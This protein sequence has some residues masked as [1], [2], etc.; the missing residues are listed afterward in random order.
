MVSPNLE[1][2]KAIEH[3]G[4]VLLS[5][6][7]GS[8]KTF[9]LENHV[10]YLTEQWIEDFQKKPQVVELRSYLR[11]KFKSVVLMTFT[12]KAAGELELRI[13]KSFE[14]KASESEI[15]Q[16]AL[17]ELPSLTVGTIHSFCLK[18]IS[19]GFFPNL[20]SAQRM[21][22]DS[23]FHA[24]IENYLE[25]WLDENKSF[26][27]TELFHK[28][29]KSL[30]Q[31]IQAIMMDPSLRVA[32]D[33]SD[34]EELGD[35]RV[36]EMIKILY[37]EFGLMTCSQD[38]PLDS[39]SE[40]KSKTWFKTFE[41]YL[42]ENS[43]FSADISG[44]LKAM[45]FFKQR[46]FKIP[47]TPTGKTL[48]QEIPIFWENIKALKDFCKNCGQDIQA[49][50]DFR[51]SHVIPWFSQ[52]KSLVSFVESEY[53][54]QE[55]LTFSDLE[56]YVFR[57][58]MRKTSVERIREQY[59]YFI[60]DEFQDTS[61]IQFEILRKLVN[62]DFNH[63]FCVGDV[64]QAI[65]GFRGGEL[66]VFMECSK[67]MGQRLSLKNN[68]R[69]AKN[70]IE[71]NNI[72]FENLFKKGKGFQ[73]LEINQI[74]YE[75]QAVP[76]TT[77]LDGSVRKILKKISPDD[78]KVSNFE[79]N[80]LE[81]Q[82]L[83][84]QIKDLP[85]NE[86]VAI[87]Y[88]KLAPSRQL[89]KLLMEAE[90]GFSAQVKVPYGEDPVVGLFFTLIQRDLNQEDENRNESALL[91]IRQYISLINGDP[92]NVSSALLMEFDR[93]HQFYGLNYAFEKFIE[94][95][96]IA[97]TKF[98]LN[99]AYIQDIIN[100]E[101]DIERI[102]LRLKRESGEANSVEFKYGENPD[103]V[104]I[105]TAHA[106][107]GLEFDHVFLGGIYTN[108]SRFPDSSL[109]GKIPSSFKW[110]ETIFGKNKYK[111]PH[112]ILEEIQTKNK[113]FSENKR[114]FY[115][116]NTRAVKTLSWVELDFSE[117][118]RERD[119]SSHWFKGIES[120]MSELNFEIE[121]IHSSDSEI[122]SDISQLKNSPPL[123]HISKGGLLLKKEKSSS[124]LLP[125]LSVTRLSQV[126]VCPRKFYLGNVCKISEDDL[127]ILEGRRS[128]AIE[129]FEVD[130]RAPTSAERGTKIHELISQLIKADYLPEKI[131]L[132]KEDRGK[133]EW[134]VENIKSLGENFDYYSE[135][136][137]KFEIFNYMVSGIP[138]L[139]ALN[140]KENKAEIWDFK[141]GRYAED[142][143]PP[144]W[145]Q[146]YAYAYALFTLNLVKEET[147]I[148]L[149][150]CFVD[151]Q[152]NIE[153]I[154]Q[155]KDVERFLNVAIGKTQTPWVV[156]TSHCQYCQFQKICKQ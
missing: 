120:V 83:L 67:K 63:L 114:L 118:K 56:F 41:D 35:A 96:D 22:S 43:H 37:Q 142:K 101:L 137:I 138:D 87:L 147:P 113:E 84:E 119:Q 29:Q 136:Q 134:A 11:Q 74:P 116:A 90:I 49:F 97:N 24:L 149:V 45:S 110:S 140:T 78:S 36:N 124:M 127:G 112:L 111:T 30:T 106:S 105:M 103:R 5:A 102:Y 62:N 117:R 65:Y 95:L 54:K 44:F 50:I 108:D 73:G 53:Q 85:L 155:L 93:N 107:K 132:N 9:V 4:G 52:I 80:Y 143:L 38:F 48:P 18:L 46:E 76:E 1:Q 40:F 128:P 21:L 55:G 81:A 20:P 64:K 13:Q 15:W 131:D 122:H 92:Q 86:E 89:I 17:K 26:E 71:F 150:L 61:Y 33:E 156:D 47:R 42:K 148:K 121:I 88:R 19:Q 8:G 99:F 75:S 152:K 91:L 31:S 25:V 39:Y 70:I 23:E 135:K 126:E 66:G 68:Y 109:I 57:G 10:I 104:K 79:I 82:S 32:W 144:Y 153:K 34:H 27:L 6:G 151:E 69:S 100:I 146:L 58:L 94:S 139:Y 115:V 51:E 72:F 12:R 129:E 133:A 77:E 125:E 3:Q 98:G 154:V 7:A 145:F 59:K 16:L 130:E 14:R 2:K 141:T 123:F 60:V 28:Q